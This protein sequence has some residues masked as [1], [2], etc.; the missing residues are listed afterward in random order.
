MFCINEMKHIEMETCGIWFKGS[1]IFNYFFTHIIL[2]SSGRKSSNSTFA[3][4][5]GP[6]EDYIPLSSIIHVDCDYDF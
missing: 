3:F 5:Q 6:A 4:K 2:D 1:S